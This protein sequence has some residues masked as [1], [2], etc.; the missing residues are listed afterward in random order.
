MQRVHNGEFALNLHY[1]GCA[2]L[3]APSQAVHAAD[4]QHVYEQ[5]AAHHVYCDVHSDEAVT[6]Q[7]ARLTL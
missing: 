4:V 3:K 2:A 6:W 7:G 5:D 1:A